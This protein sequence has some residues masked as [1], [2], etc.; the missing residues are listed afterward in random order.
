M[1]RKVDAA[2]NF[3]SVQLIEQE[4]GTYDKRLPDYAGQD[5]I[6]VYLAWGRISHETKEFGMCLVLYEKYKHLS[7][8]CHRKTDVPNVFLS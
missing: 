5:K 4:P 7:L 8:N 6:R 1:A 3:V 2:A